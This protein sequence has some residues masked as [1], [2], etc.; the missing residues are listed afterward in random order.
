MGKKHVL[1]FPA[2]AENGI[3]IYQ[4][5]KRNVHFEAYGA[6]GREDHSEYIYPAE[7]LFVS[8]RLYIDHP[9]FI[10]ELNRLV[11]QWAID[12]IMPTHDTVV[13]ALLEEQERLHAVV[14]SSP[15]ETA[16]VAEDKRLIYERLRGRP[17]CPAVYERP[18]EIQYP[19]FLK[20]CI[21]SGGKGTA[22]VNDAAAYAQAEREVPGR[23]ICEYLP[24]RE[25]TIDCFTDCRGDLLFIGPRIRERIT[26]GISYSTQC[27][28]LT[29]EIKE[30]A[31]DLNDRFQFRGAWFFQLKEDKNH[32]LKLLEFSVRQAGTMAFY[33]HLGVNFAALSLFDRMGYPVRILYNDFSLRLDRGTETLYRADLAYDTI[34]LDYDDTLI[35]NGRV[36]LQ[37]I[38]LIYQAAAQNINIVLLTK[39][40]G[41]INQSLKEHRLS[42]ALFSQVIV[43]PPDGKKVEY[44]KEKRAIFIDN[45]FPERQQVYEQCRIPVFDVDAVD[46]LI[47]CRGI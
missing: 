38:Q 18:D 35:V 22:V 29:T 8:D 33:R 34:Y 25:Y 43:L 42:E 36:N 47:D 32:R 17:Y 28:L 21:A 9:Q 19:A 24:G 15:L 39:H 1:I 13:R 44:I 23:L 2:G 30:I 26:G 10:N 7:R 3:D 40:K 11:E 46:C 27:T 14:V 45:H 37:M 12:Y 4:S 6:S 16:R 5:I 41:D 20:P 31:A